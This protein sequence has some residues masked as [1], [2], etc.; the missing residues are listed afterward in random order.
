VTIFGDHIIYFTYLHI[1]EQAVILTSYVSLGLKYAVLLWLHNVWVDKHIVDK[2]SKCHYGC[3]SVPTCLQWS[4][5]SIER[6]KRGRTD[7]RVPPR[8]RL[9]CVYDL[10]VRSLTTVADTES[11]GGRKDAGTRPSKETSAFI[12]VET[13]CSVAWLGGNRRSAML[14][15]KQTRQS[16]MQKNVG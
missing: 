2:T 15:S 4:Q 10:I 12:Q 1:A 6:T 13:N 16:R 11:V 8:G 5:L 9:W 14:I 3:D 7:Q